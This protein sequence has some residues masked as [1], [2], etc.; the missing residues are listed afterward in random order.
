MDT[1]AALVAIG[2]I[3]EYWGPLRKVGK[4]LTLL[5]WRVA[6][7]RLLNI[8]FP[9][10]VVVGVA[11]EFAI[12]LRVSLI[13]NEWE[14]SQL[15]RNL[16]ETQQREI[17]AKLKPFSGMHFDLEMHQDI[18]PLRLLDKIENALLLAGWLE[19][20]PRAD[21]QQFDRI[22]R[23]KVAVGRTVA[24]V[25]ILWSEGSGDR[26]KSAAKTLR[27]ALDDD[28]V[29]ASFVTVLKPD[30]YDLD[31]IHVWVGAKP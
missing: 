5:N 9:L 21:H 25:W 11:A 14:I 26:S 16:S 19:Q 24:G 6:S 7:L 17:A 4:S 20:P 29:A 8:I 23:P 3:G 18:E 27:D 31:K 22:T 10:L 30:A 12:S 1:A 28:G 13:E 2:L 15:P